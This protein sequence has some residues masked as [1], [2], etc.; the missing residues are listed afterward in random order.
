MLGRQF[1]IL[2]TDED[3]REIESALLRRGDVAFLSDTTEDDGLQLRPLK[4]LVRNADGDARKLGSVFCYLVPV[5]GNARVVVD[6][7]SSVKVDVR[8]EE[9]ECLELWRSH[10]NQGVIRRGRIY[11]TPRYFDGDGFHDKDSAFVKWA[12]RVAAT[13]K[14]SLSFDRVLQSQVGPDAARRI[15]SGEL[16]VIA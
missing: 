3:L 5:Q 2:V 14:K 7:S 12:G 4:S 6:R 11:Y 16:K 9:S 10:C 15:S 13:I 1:S 8:I